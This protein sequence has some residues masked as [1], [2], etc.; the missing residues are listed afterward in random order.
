MEKIKEL[1][2][3]SGAGI[4]DCKKA[5]EESGGDIDKA[6]EILR[7]KGIAKAAKRGER[8]ASEGMVLV[9][10]NKNG[11]EGYILEINSETD[12]VA[13][14]E[15]FRNFAG[16]VFDLIKKDK[17]ADLGELMKLSM[18]TGNV[19]ESLDNL[20]GTIGE[21]LS[22]K[23]FDILSGQS[24]ADYSHLGGRIG[25]LVSLNKSG[26]A[27][28]AR[29]IAM[30]VAAANPKYIKPEDVPVEELEKEKEIYREQ[31]KKEGK[32]ENII[33]KILEGK[34]KKYYEEVCLIK[35][36]Y[37]KDDKKKVKDILGEIEMEKFVRY[38]L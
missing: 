30:Q 10:V 32:P 7:K 14:N 18:E 33:E 4:V 29:D 1:R 28:L 21:K 20:S 3:K 5:L 35:Q 19:Q 22:I 34:I 17:P 13:R 23:K 37:I 6:V 9:D 12:F 27:D 8:E 24:V 38:S 15:Q 2:E 11:N 25:V 31:L 16:Q 36:E 26:Q